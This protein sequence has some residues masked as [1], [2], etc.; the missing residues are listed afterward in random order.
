MK[1]EQNVTEAM[2]EAG[3]SAVRNLNFGKDIVAL[4][5]EGS[6]QIAR[7]A[8]EAAL[9]H[10]PSAAPVAVKVK[11]VRYL[12]DFQ[13]PVTGSF[14]ER[15]GVNDPTGE[16]RVSNVR[17]LYASPAIET[18]AVP[19]GWKLVPIEPTEDMVTEGA[20]ACGGYDYPSPRSVWEAMLTASPTGGAS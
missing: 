17:P 14:V 10:S 18:P 6:K 7:A 5:I 15:V 8:L 4:G 2:V 13:D 11:P 1:N 20:V 9:R 12:C 16:P 19:E 3:A